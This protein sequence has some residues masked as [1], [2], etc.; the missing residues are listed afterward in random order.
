VNAQDKIAKTLTA[1]VMITALVVSFAHIVITFDHLGA[2]WD[3]WIAPFMIDTIAIIGKIYGDDR[4]TAATRRAGRRAFQVAGTL[5]LIANVL[6]GFWSDH[7]GSMIIGVITVSAALWG[8]SM[9][10]KGQVKASAIKAQAAKVNK[11]AK[12]PEQIK[13]S[14]AARKAAATRKANK[15]A[16]AA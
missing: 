1:G 4:Y 8:E 14:A 3:K 9:I 7:Y 11:D 12:T 10:S 16:A 15:I 6:A 13:R 5:S 2:G